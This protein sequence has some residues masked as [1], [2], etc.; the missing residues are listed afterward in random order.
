MLVM[1]HVPDEVWDSLPPKRLPRWRV[2]GATLLVALLGMGAYAAAQ[3]GVL[4]PNV[5]AQGNGGSWT[6]G[7]DT[8]T[9]VVTLTND[10]SV[11][12]TIESVALSSSTWV[13][14]DRVTQADARSTDLA[15]AALPSALPVTLGAHEGMSIELWFTVTDCAAIDR[16]G[17]ALTATAASP[18]RTTALDI[19]PRADQDPDAPSFYTWSD[20]N[21]PWL[22]PWPGTYAASACN[23][24]VP[25]PA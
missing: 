4:A 21:N 5:A 3:A 23:V 11:P 8:F 25:P 7:S 17:L 20:G 24:P 6:E 15:G 1:Q 16:A 14:L 10:G 19:T 9:S 18:M 13:R 22:V 12:V 2:L